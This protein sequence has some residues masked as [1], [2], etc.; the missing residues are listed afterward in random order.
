MVELAVI[1]S[2]PTRNRGRNH[3]ANQWQAPGELRL[4]IKACELDS[5]RDNRNWATDPKAY[6][7]ES[8]NVR[9]P[10]K[11]GA[12][13]Q[14][15]DEKHRPFR[16]RGALEAGMAVAQETRGEDDKDDARNGGKNAGQDHHAF[17]HE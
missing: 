14:D 7:A 8:R 1:V 17:F 12:E 15:S 3:G 5:P 4:A 16:H 13:R 6:E 10:G 11:R 2:Q 9:E